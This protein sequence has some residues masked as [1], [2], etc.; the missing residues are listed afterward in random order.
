CVD[1]VDNHCTNCDSGFPI[2]LGPHAGGSTATPTTVTWSDNSTCTN[3]TYN[4]RVKSIKPWVA[5]WPSDYSNSK[6]VPVQPA[7]AP[8]AVTATRVS[9]TQIN[10]TW[11]YTA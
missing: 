3:S 1:D 6:S 8:T 7:L 11:S 9:E 2:I 5:D 10:L 4:Y